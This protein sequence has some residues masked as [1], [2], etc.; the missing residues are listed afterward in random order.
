MKEEYLHL[1]WNKKRIP[2]HQM[3]LTNGQEFTVK[4]SGF[5]NKE[6]GPDFF[7]GEVLIDNITW[8]GNIEIHV[9]SSD[10]ILHKHTSDLAYD[11]VILHV[12]YEHDKE[13]FV[14]ERM[15]PTLELKSVIDQKHFHNYLKLKNSS[16][17]F[18]CEKLIHE[19]DPI[20]LETMKEKVIIQRLNRKVSD[21]VNTNKVNEENDYGQIL[22]E[23][24]AKSFGMKVN[25]QPFLELTKRLPLKIIKRER[26]EYVQSLII[27]TSG[28][29][30]EES[31]QNALDDWLFLKEKYQLDC[32]QK[33]VWKKKGLR[34]SGFPLIRLSQFSEVIQKF[35]FDTTFT[36]LNATEL[37]EYLYALLDVSSR[38]NKKTLRLSKSTKET[39][40]VNSFIP[41]LWWFGQMRNDEKILDKVIDILLLLGKESNNILLKWQEIGVDVNNAY[42]SQALLEIYNEFCFRKK[43]LFCTLGDKIIKNLF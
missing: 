6:S 8:R 3:K 25:S 14:G 26:K 34:S 16:L 18:V 36:Y 7:D 43:C 23:L 41:F 2:F 31:N 38:G 10:W 19:F 30:E 20:Y 17:D 4:K 40:I 5:H 42:D 33:Y 22:Y 27:G 35:D 24:V 11:N 1:I 9:K 29:I 28:F 39:I 21:F 13:I 32:M 15:L 12:V 37:I